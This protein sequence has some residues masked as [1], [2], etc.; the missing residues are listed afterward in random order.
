M[1]TQRSP[2]SAWSDGNIP[3]LSPPSAAHP[4]AR[5]DGISW[6]ASRIAQEFLFYRQRDSDQDS[7]HPSAQWANIMK[8]AHT[9]RCTGLLLTT[10]AGAGTLAAAEPT[11]AQRSTVSSSRRTACTCRSPP[12]A[13]AGSRASGISVRPPFSGPP[14]PHASDPLSSRVL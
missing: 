9:A 2:A 13:T 12:T 7:N 10:R 1:Q 11:R 6:S 4:P 8:Y 14:A 5:T 3:A